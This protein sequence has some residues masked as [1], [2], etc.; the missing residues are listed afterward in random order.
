MLDVRIWALV[1]FVQSV[2]Y[3]AATLV[4]LISASPSLP[5]SLVGP[6]AEMR[7]SGAPYGGGA[8]DQSGRRI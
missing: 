6:M 4:S 3:L 8:D 1:L 5:A 7:S 2:P